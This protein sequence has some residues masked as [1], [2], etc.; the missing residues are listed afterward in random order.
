MDKVRRRAQ[1]DLYDGRQ[2]PQRV[3][4][5]FPPQLT[6][7]PTTLSPTDVPTPLANAHVCPA[8]SMSVTTKPPSS[9]SLTKEL[10]I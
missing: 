6:V 4:S 7:Q 5:T 3:F 8:T 9:S 10:T 2:H 1:G